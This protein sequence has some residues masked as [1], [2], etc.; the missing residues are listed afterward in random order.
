VLGAKA[1]WCVRGARDAHTGSGVRTR[2]T[3]PPPPPLQSP[4]AAALCTFSRDASY[5]S[6]AVQQRAAACASYS[7]PAAVHVIKNTY[8]KLPV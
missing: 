8:Y 3:P 2:D 4:A 1:S 6:V 7:R 5:S